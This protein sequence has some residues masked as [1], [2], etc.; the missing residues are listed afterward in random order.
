MFLP[1]DE[2]SHFDVLSGEMLSSKE[3]YYCRKKS[4]RLLYL[5]LRIIFVTKVKDE[6]R[7]DLMQKMQRMQRMQK[8]QS[9]RTFFFQMAA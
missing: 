5:M 6:H 1:F 9:C 8:M 4:Y 7:A 2:S 3:Y